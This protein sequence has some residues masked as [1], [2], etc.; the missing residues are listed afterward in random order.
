MP[1]IPDRVGEELQRLIFE[2]RSNV[3]KGMVDYLAL[4]HRMRGAIF[5]QLANAQRAREEFR[6]AMQVAGPSVKLLVL[7]LIS[8]LPRRGAQFFYRA[9]KDFSTRRA[10][11]V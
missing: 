1:A 2:C 9:M 6:R 10:Q 3:P 4:W 8:A 11:R 7:F 5:L